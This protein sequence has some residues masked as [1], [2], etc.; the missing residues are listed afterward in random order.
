MLI[1]LK[2]KNGPIHRLLGIIGLEQDKDKELD[3]EDKQVIFALSDRILQ[4]LE[5]RELQN[6][7]YNAVREL[8]PQVE[9]FQ[10]LK[11]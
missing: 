4:A 5:N 2:T 8:N 7:L 10:K 1:P 6:E 11:C 3:P 9:Q